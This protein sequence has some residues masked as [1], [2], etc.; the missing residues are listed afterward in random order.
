M[1]F[2]P[3]DG[4]REPDARDAAPRG[5][6]VARLVARLR[7]DMSGDGLGQEFEVRRAGAV[8]GDDG[9]DDAV[10]AVREQFGPQRVLV[11]LAADRRAAFVAGVAVLD[12]LGREGEVVGAGFGGDFDAVGACFAEERDRLHGGEVDDVER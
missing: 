3:Q 10:V 7:H 5:E 8:V 12:V 4:Q 6:E 1:Q 2:R 9:L 11:Q